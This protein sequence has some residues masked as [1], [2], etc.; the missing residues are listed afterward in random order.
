MPR[1]PWD[2]LWCLTPI[3]DDARRDSP[4]I[5]R[6][7]LLGWRGVTLGRT[8]PGITEEIGDASHFGGE[9]NIKL[10]MSDPQPSECQDSRHDPI[11][12]TIAT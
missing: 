3:E 5:P 10:P 9:E 8:V 12:S 11:A 7:A 6:L 1:R 2:A 4:V